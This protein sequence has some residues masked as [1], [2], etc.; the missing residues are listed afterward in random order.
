[1]SPWGENCPYREARTPPARGASLVVGE[2]TDE[3]GG[4]GSG[5]VVGRGLPLAELRVDGDGACVVAGP[6]LSWAM[7]ARVR[8]ARLD[9]TSGVQRTESTVRPH[10]RAPR[11]LISVQGYRRS[12]LRAD[13][14]AGLTVW[15]VLVPESL[16]YAT[17]AGVPPVVGLYAAVPPLV[18]YAAARLL[19]APGRRPHVGDGGAV[20]RD[21]RR[22][23]RRRH[24]GVRAPPLP[25]PSSPVCRLRSPGCCA[26]LHRPRSSP[27][28]CSRASSSGSH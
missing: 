18:L 25:S 17:I 27:S 1:M 8:V 26:R 19:P 20:R 5:L 21:R 7:S 15:A 4:V 13:L 6:H 2:R 11:L 12:W 3:V 23:R 14:L 16:A 22:V 24:R 10:L 28:R 9:R